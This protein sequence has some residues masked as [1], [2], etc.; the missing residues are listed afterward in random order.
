MFVIQATRA[1]M[2]AKFAV[3][4]DADAFYIGADVNDPSPM[5]NMRDPRT[6]P[7]RGWDADSC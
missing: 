3:M 5:M 6:D 2:N 4:Y 1:T 7:G